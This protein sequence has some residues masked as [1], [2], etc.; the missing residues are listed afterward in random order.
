METRYHILQ[1]QVDPHR[2]PL[3]VVSA[4][5]TAE[6][7]FRIAAGQLSALKES[8]KRDPG[9]LSNLCADRVSADRTR[10]RLMQ[11]CHRV[12]EQGEVW[13]RSSNLPLSFPDGTCSRR[14]GVKLLK[15][16]LNAFTLAS[17]LLDLI[18]Q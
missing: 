6:E 17:D 5:T 4:S 15:E 13:E 3:A 2:P 10:E 1:D 18:P 11:L 7:L 8:V 9:Q 12:Q 14:L 16:A